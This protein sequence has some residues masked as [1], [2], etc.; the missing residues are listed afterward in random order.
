MRFPLAATAVILAVLLALDQVQSLQFQFPKFSITDQSRLSLSYNSSIALGAI[1]VTPDANGASM[2]NMAGRTL[3]GQPFRLWRN[4]GKNANF[5][6]TFVLNVKSMT[7]SSGEGL[8]FI[9]TADRAVP[10]GSVGQWLGI[11]NSS[12]NGTPEAQIVAVEFDTR[13][14]F[15]EDLDDNHIGLDVNS[16]YSKRSVSLNDSGIYISAAK[17]IKVVVQYDGKNLTVF[18]GDDMKNP[19]LSEPLD[20]SAHL[21][22]MVYIGFS[23]STSDHTQLNCV[24]SWEFTGSEMKKPKLWWVWIMVAVS[25]LI[26]LVGIGVAFFFY[27][28]RGYEGNRLDNACPNIEEEILGFSTAP[29]KYKFKELSRATGKFNPKNKLGKGGFGTVYKGVLGGKEVAVKRVSKKST[30]GKQEFIAEV[31]TIGNIR[32][33]NLVK[34][35]GWCHEKREYL[36]VYEYLPKGSLDKYIFWDE[37]SGTQEE[38]L[39][40]GKR[41]GVITGVAHAVEYL[42]NGCTNRVLH[43]DIKASNV[44]L[45]F[46]SDAK[47]GDFGLA[48]TMI[49]NEQTHHSTKELAGTPGYMAPESI[50]TGRATAETDVYAFGVL[51]L[52]VACGRKPGG[53]AERDDYISN[54]VHGLWELYRR[55]TILEGADPRLNGIFKK[56]EMERVLILGLACCHPSPKSRPSMK[57]VLQ[58]L[59]GEAPPP[60]VPAERPAFMWPPMPPSFKECDNSLVGGQLTPFTVLSGR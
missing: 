21:P 54:I 12:L 32:H 18:V 46:N 57:T 53:Q 2:E 60:E 8:A 34:L 14:S 11:V 33:R 1:Q 36:L 5:N 10:D 4:K 45:D 31:T 23:G 59:T 38:T 50:L 20:L 26:L 51:I 58:V 52:E 44:M 6:T 40:W 22:E 3:Y 49:H 9:L 24:K 48:R 17:D 7:A 15:P 13:K 16:V 43:R 47:L 41:L 39:S 42:H 35:I 25:V 37:K 27:R 29:K 19:V 28:K 55:G 56:E 30:Q